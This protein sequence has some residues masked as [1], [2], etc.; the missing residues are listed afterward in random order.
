[1][2]VL[3]KR[4][5]ALVPNLKLN[6]WFLDD[7]TIIGTIDEALRVLQICLEEGP[8]LGLHAKLKKTELFWP[9]QS[10]RLQEFPAIIERMPTAGVTLLGSAI[11]S[12]AHVE[13]DFLE[14]LDEMAATLDMLDELDDKQM[15]LQ[16]MQYCLGA[17][18]LAHAISTAAPHKLHNALPRAEELIAG[19]LER[20][21]SSPLTLQARKQSALPLRHGG[22]GVP[23]VCDTAEASFISSCFFTRSLQRQMLQR[24]DWLPPGVSSA[25]AALNIRAGFA[26]GEAG[27]LL[28]E[29]FTVEGL[30]ANPPRRKQLL[31][32][33][34]RRTFTQLLEGSTEQGQARLRAVSMEGASDWMGAV[35]TPWNKMQPREVSTTLCLRLGLPVYAADRLCPCNKAICDLLGYHALSCAQYGDR[36]LRHNTLRDVV[37][38]GARKAGLSPARE[39]QHLLQDSGRKPGDVYLPSFERGAPTALDTVVPS[40]CTVSACSQAAKQQGFAAAQAEEAKRASSFDVCRQNGIHFLPMAIEAF[41]G[42][43]QSAL[44]VVRKIGAFIAQRTGRSEA[45]EIRYFRQRLSL[46]LH[47]ANAAMV[48]AR[49][50]L[51]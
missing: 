11:G 48:Q 10:P 40:P 4:I 19:A 32:P 7:G 25:L 14:R 8:A 41:G 15:A 36:V 9:T 6:E 16:L 12:P 3:A 43:G 22:L 51:C 49:A 50:P 5:S 44:S 28:P 21:V 29:A 30:A 1:L 47:R 37:Y 17:P 27:Q 46:A 31:E 26:G 38:E 35:P 2:D 20:I 23:N 18:T 13:Q 34:Y 39:K 42:L 33:C 24:D 45:E